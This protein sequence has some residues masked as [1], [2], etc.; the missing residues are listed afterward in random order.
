L[1]AGQTISAGHVRRLTSH[2]THIGESRTEEGGHLSARGLS[3]QG[4]DLS[5]LTEQ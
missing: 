1:P 2:S 5:K 4:V 3:R